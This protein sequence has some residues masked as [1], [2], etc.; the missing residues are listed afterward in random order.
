M[1]KVNKQ[2]FLKYI[3]LSGSLVVVSFF[4]NSL[5]IVHLDYNYNVVF[6]FSF[7]F[8]NI[9]SYLGN[10]F[11]TFNHQPKISKYIIFLQ[12]TLFTW[13]SGMI[14]VNLIEIFYAPNKLILVVFMT[15]YTS[16][17]NFILNLRRIFNSNN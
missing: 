10:S 2:K 16:I 7:F 12:N 14:M 3:S 17:L 6:V 15:T 1:I 9:L 4:F 13:I 11:Y 8:F 5:F